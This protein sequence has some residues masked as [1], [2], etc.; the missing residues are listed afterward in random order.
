MT[1]KQKIIDRVRLMNLN[2]KI[3]LFFSVGSGTDRGD[4]VVD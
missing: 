3:T 4:G 1:S 2:Q